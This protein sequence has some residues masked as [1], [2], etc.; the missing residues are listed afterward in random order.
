MIMT[1]EPLP[2]YHLV[3]HADPQLVHLR[4]ILQQKLDSVPGVASRLS[5]VLAAH[6][7][8]QP[9]HSLAEKCTKEK[10]SS[11]VLYLRAPQLLLA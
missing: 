9:P 8:Q 10:A 2:L 4:E 7:W 6:V 3:L 11:R 5:G 1:Q